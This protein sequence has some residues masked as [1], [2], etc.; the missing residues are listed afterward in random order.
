[1]PALE[2]RISLRGPRFWMDD[3][4]LMF[5]NQIDGSTREGPREATSADRHNFPTALEGMMAQTPN[6][7]PPGQPLISTKDPDII[8]APAPKPYAERRARAAEA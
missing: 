3:G 5:C 1:M 8:P 4:K 2:R 7:D 6:A